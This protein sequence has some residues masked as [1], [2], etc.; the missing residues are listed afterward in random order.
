IYLV[1]GVGSV[2]ALRQL[3]S[4]KGNVDQFDSNI[5]PGTL[6]LAKM[7]SVVSQARGD[8]HAITRTNP[9]LTP[10]QAAVARKENADKVRAELADV[11]NLING[12]KALP[13]TK[14][15]RDAQTDFDKAWSAFAAA[16]DKMVVASVSPD[17]A[18]RAGASDIG[19]GEVAPVQ[20]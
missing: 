5:L 11:Q 17:E 8:A 4:V 2:L 6:A 19:T 3:Q 7:P 1:I 13:L 20:T 12:Y 15:Q 18:V 9:K 14:A 10:E 16:M